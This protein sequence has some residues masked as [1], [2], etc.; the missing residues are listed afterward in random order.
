MAQVLEKK[1]ISPAHDG[2]PMRQSCLQDE[3][4][5]EF[6]SS[7]RRAHCFTAGHS[8]QSRFP[9]VAVVP[10]YDPGLMVFHADVTT[11]EEIIRLVADRLFFARRTEN[12]RLIEEALWQREAA[13][14]TG[15]GNGFAIPHC[16]TGVVSAN[17]LVIIKPRSPLSWNS[18]DNQKVDVILALIIREKKFGPADLEVLSGLAQCLMRDDFRERLRVETSPPRLAG[19]LK[20][21]LAA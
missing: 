9:A 13:G 3:I 14:P 8:P 18:A 6:V 2:L 11:P 19:W 4:M 5:P 12:A 1:I 20:G 17:S 15:L 10:L 16:R 7:R 21:K